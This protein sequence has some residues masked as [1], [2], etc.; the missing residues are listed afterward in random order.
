[1]NKY[2]FIVTSAINSRFGI[3]NPTERLT[4]TLDTIASIKAK[5][6]ESPIFLLDMCGDKLLPEQKDQLL[7]QVTGLTEFYENKDVQNIYKIDNHDIVKNLTE[8]LCFREFI[9][10]AIENQLFN[11]RRRIFKVSGRY[12][13]SDGFSLAEY[14]D[15]KYD[16]CL[17]FAK[18]RIS[19]F[20]TTI[21]GNKPN[22]NFQYMSRL[23]SYAANIQSLVYFA[24]DYM[25]KDMVQRVNLGGY[26]DIEHLLYKYMRRDLI[27]ERDVVGLK[28]QIAP[29]G[30]SVED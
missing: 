4:Q 22:D 29:N 7:V 30:M 2:A 15:P 19:Q 14:D 5:A 26:I 8:M 25:I 11:D 3:F 9:G 12:I 23:W 6:P 18:R 20:P 13:L 28:G 17:V 27:I 16:E 10:Y 1:M 24:Y 21:T